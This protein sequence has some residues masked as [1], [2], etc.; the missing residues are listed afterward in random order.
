MEQY[1]LTLLFSVR[2]D[3]YK[4]GNESAREIL[5]KLNGKLSKEEDMGERP[6]AY[7]V[8]KEE[9]GHYLFWDIELESSA[10][11]AL[12]EALQACGSVL[13]YLLLKK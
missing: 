11:E 9:H 4:I 8:R 10:V 2:E 6:L 7:P 13:K 5:Q 12:K 1:E 3:H